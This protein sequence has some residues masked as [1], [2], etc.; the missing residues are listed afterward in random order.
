M[1]NNI[2]KKKTWVV[3][4]ILFMIIFLPVTQGLKLTD[5]S[6]FEKTT[7]NTINEGTLSGFV[8]DSSNNSIEGALV[9]VYFHE[10]YRENYSDYYG[11]YHVIDI[12]I[13]YCIKNATCSKEGYQTEYVLLSIYE[14]TTYDFT[15]YPLDSCYPSYNGTIGWNGWYISPV[16]VSFTYNPEEVAEIWYNYNGWHNYSETF[17]IDEQGSIIVEY[18]WIDYEGVQSPIQNFVVNIDQTPPNTEI[19]WE[20]FKV[21]FRWYINFKINAND[22]TSGMSSFLFTYINDVL[23]SEWMVFDWENV[24]FGCVLTKNYRLI[25][26]GFACFDNA[27]NQAYE[28]VNGTDIKSF[29]VNQRFFHQK[30][31]NRYFQNSIDYSN[32][33]FFQ[34]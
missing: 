14:N 6:A 23:Q 33:L 3:L 24:E 12:P 22:S 15:L 9:R 17:T 13:C 7:F 31:F 10:E 26:F 1:K 30:F 20:V 4:P 19:Q 5:N 27:G 21:G 28:S 25:T 18:Y 29:N 34:F 8:R 32:N 16:Q 11:Y 2:L